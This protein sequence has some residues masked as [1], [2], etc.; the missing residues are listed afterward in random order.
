LSQVLAY[1]LIHFGYMPQNTYMLLTSILITIMGL[2]LL[3][4]ILE[5]D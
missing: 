5:K 4:K 3:K 1:R 2:V